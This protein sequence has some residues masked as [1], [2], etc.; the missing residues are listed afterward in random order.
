MILYGAGPFL[1]KVYETALSAS[2]FPTAYFTEPIEETPSLPI[3][4]M[5]PYS[6]EVCPGEGIF[7]AFLD[8][9]IRRNLFRRVRHPLSKPLIHPLAQVEASAKIGAGTFVGADVQIGAEATIGPLVIIEEQARIGAGV[10]IAEGAYI[11]PHTQIE[12]G[13]QI[14]PYVYLGA[15]AILTPMAPAQVLPIGEGSLIGPHAR[16]QT[17]CPP[18]CWVPPARAW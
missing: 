14:G 1:Q 4:F 16:I 17:P 6:S 2:E 18:F 15:G 7:L 5:G 10:E 12:T 13:V 3:P 8:N 11:G 9:T